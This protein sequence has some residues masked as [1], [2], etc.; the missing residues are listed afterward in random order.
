MRIVALLLSF[1]T[2]LVGC[3]TVKLEEHSYYLM[4]LPAADGVG[5]AASPAH[6]GIRAVQVAPY[7]EERGL[8]F[9]TTPNE[10][11]HARFHKWSEPVG[12]GFTSVMRA[13]L[14]DS[15]GR[16][17]EEDPSLTSKWQYAID[18]TIDR[19]HGT[20]SGDA[21]LVASWRITRI[22][23]GDEISFH[24]FSQRQPLSQP[25]YPALVAAEISLTRAFSIAVA[26]SLQ[27]IH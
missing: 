18:V 14:T 3:S 25:G 7:L 10:I 8:A 23:D 15:L 24:R 17:V 13:Q 16:D 21:L 5:V 2:L 9:E 22:S 11:H 27:N 6:V 12:N 1:S 4:R 26:D 19:F 20:A